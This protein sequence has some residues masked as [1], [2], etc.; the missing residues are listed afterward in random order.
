[1]FL[2]LL[3]VY[4]LAFTSFHTILEIGLSLYRYLPPSL[5]PSIQN[6]YQKLVVRFASWHSS[7]PLP[8]VK[9]NLFRVLNLFR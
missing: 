9:R 8:A 2:N 7:S 1:M 6:N 4:K 3:I 5:P